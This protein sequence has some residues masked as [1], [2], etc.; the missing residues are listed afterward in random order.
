MSR[1]SCLL[2]FFPPLILLTFCLFFSQKSFLLFHSF[3]LFLFWRKKMRLIVG[4]INGLLKSMDTS[5]LLASQHQSP[6]W[7]PKPTPTLLYLVLTYWITTTNRLQYRKWKS[8]HSMGNRRSSSRNHP[9]RK[10]FP[11]L[12]SP[13]PRSRVCKDYTDSVVLMAITTDQKQHPKVL[14]R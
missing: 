10:S 11:L 12:L 8:G 13:I 3:F 5:P 9:D 2:S 4:S 6:I 7:N 1:V 14:C